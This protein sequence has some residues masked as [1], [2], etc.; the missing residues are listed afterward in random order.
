[1]KKSHALGL[2]ML[3]LITGLFVA[4]WSVAQSGGRPSS[5][6]GDTD[7]AFGLHELESFVSYLQDTKQT[8]TLSRFNDYSNAR[9]ASEASAQMGVTA[10][11]LLRL[12]DGRTNEAIRLLEMRLTGDA[13]GF[14]ASYR[15]LPA[16]VRE[17]VS[18]IPL[19]HA[20]DYCSKYNV[21]E[22][23]PDL[24]QI[25]SNAFALLDQKTTK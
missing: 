4:N 14:A 19:Q 10:A 22:S 13:V 9:I 20:R 3:A 24:D 23:H 25:V 15:E 11:I 12:Q 17:R 7:D 8:N 6:T 5:K 1:M 18:L 2:L 21:K 16:S